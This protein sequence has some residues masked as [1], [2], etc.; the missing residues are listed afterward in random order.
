M[1]LFDKDKPPIESDIESDLE[2]MKTGLFYLFTM[3]TPA[4]SRLILKEKEEMVLKL[5]KKARSSVQYKVIK[6]G[7]KVSV[8][9]INEIY[10][11]FLKVEQANGNFQNFSLNNIDTPFKNSVL[12]KTLEKLNVSDSDLT[13]FKYLSS[14]QFKVDRL[15]S[16]LPKIEPFLENKNDLRNLKY[17]QF[18]KVQIEYIS[19]LKEEITHTLNEKKSL[20][21]K[22]TISAL[23]SVI[24]LSA[25]IILTAIAGFK[26]GFVAILLTKF[27]PS[28]YTD[29][30]KNIP[31]AFN[32][33]K[34]YSDV[35][36]LQAG[37]IG[38]EFN[39]LCF[40]L[41]KESL[42]IKAT[43]DRYNI[44]FKAPEA[45]N[46]ETILNPSGLG[47]NPA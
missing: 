19:K 3:R 4:L 6:E 45:E 27:L 7:K 31:S 9:N 35:I 18:L 38:I 40:E 34:E 41:L 17:L 28:K 36:D 39:H 20:Y 33:L 14:L 43:I 23:F 15:A 46:L 1:R 47:L 32:S 24:I 5:N 21:H 26:I 16:E 12:N 29:V 30:V 13:Y 11:E 10:N 8:S 2:E 42:E 22:E 25:C 37:K 44:L